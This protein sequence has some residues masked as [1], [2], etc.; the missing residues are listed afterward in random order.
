[1]L[2]FVIAR[3]ESG[4]WP[5]VQGMCD[6]DRPQKGIC[7]GYAIKHAA[8]LFNVYEPRVSSYVV[9]GIRRRKPLSTARLFWAA[10][11]IATYN[12][13]TGRTFRQVMRVL[14]RARAIAKAD[15]EP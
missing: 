11:E 1:M 15:A 6:V 8:K 10:S 9:Q 14:E 5:W 3:F 4:E 12:D 7:A 2:D 13:R